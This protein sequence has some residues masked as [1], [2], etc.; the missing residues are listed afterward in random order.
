M[1]KLVL[2]HLAGFIWSMWSKQIWRSNV[3]RCQIL[4]LMPH[5][6]NHF[7]SLSP[8]L[9]DNTNSQ[10]RETKLSI[11]SIFCPPVSWNIRSQNS[12]KVTETPEWM[13]QS[14]RCEI[15]LRVSVDGSFSNKNNH[16]HTQ[17]PQRSWLIIVHAKVNHWTWVFSS[18][19]SIIEL[20]HETGDWSISIKAQSHSS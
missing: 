11:V 3:I 9:F 6:S 4:N 17:V 20:D 8:V 2:W 10:E 18:S 19:C 16:R 12:F 13:V 5:K 14:L 7:Y 1:W 15:A